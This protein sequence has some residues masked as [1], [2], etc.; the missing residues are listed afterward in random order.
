MVSAE[1]SGDR[2]RRYVPGWGDGDERMVL[3]E[4]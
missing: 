2:V 3:G 4:A 1:R